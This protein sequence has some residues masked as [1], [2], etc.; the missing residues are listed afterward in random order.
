[1]R[2]RP[3]SLPDDM[4]PHGTVIEWWYWNG[5]LEDKHGKRYAYMDCLFRADAKQVN[6]PYFKSILSHGAAGNH[7]LFAHS[8][9][10]DL[11]AKRTYKNV[12]N[13][14]FASR[15]SFT[16]PLFYV[17]YLDPIAAAAG[18]VV[19]A[20]EESKGGIFHIKT[21]RIDLVM[22]SKK[23]PLLEGGNG[24]ITV[25]GRKSFYYSLT[26]L[27]TNGAV[28]VGDEW[29]T[30]K[31]RS[32]MDHQWADVPYTKDKWTWFSFRL[33]D[34]TDL[35]CVEYDDGNGKDY[36]V[37]LIDP[38]GVS[39]HADHAEFM[40]GAKKWKSKATQAS[41]PLTWTIIVPDR[42]IALE[43]SAMLPDQEMIFGAIN[44]WEGPVTVKGMI[45][46]RRVSGTGFME[47]AGYPSHYNYLQD[48]IA[49]QIKNIIG[50][51]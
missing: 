35:M 30:V 34:G 26:D 9:F 33:D 12:Q 31:G 7:V 15:D 20:M 51:I 44:Y 11:G 39:A 18:F 41:Y 50:A 5:L 36:V 47:L 42:E 43:A 13:I 10:A 48:Q 27:E 1:M 2:P 22:A 49:K 14:S 17:E 40:P 4:M 16:R 46:K 21:D 19:H 37:D 3:I 45:G 8:M 24:F 32:W 6:I 29:V 23:R 38:H 25:R 28:L